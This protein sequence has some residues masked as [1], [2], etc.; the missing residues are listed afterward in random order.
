MKKSLK[1]YYGFTLVE[2]IIVITILAI[3][4]TIA[5][6]S[7]QNYTK[8]SR[9]T[10]R[11]SSLKNIE[12]GLE[13]FSVT[14]GN[15]PMPDKKVDILSSWSVIWYQ[16]YAWDSVLNIIKSSKAIDPLDWLYYNY[17]VDKDLKKYELLTFME[18]I[19]Y[20]NIDTTYA[21]INRIWK[22]YWDNIWII[23][24]ANNVP[25]QELFSTGIDL[26]FVTNNFVLHL[27]N[28]VKITWTWNI[29]K[30]FQWNNLF[31]SLIWYW[32]FDDNSWTNYSSTYLK[33]ITTSS[34][35]W[36]NTIS[37]SAWKIGNWVLFNWSSSWLTF[38]IWSNYTDYN[39]WTTI[40]FFVKTT[41]SYNWMWNASVQFWN[42]WTHIY[43]D[44][45]NPL[46]IRF[47]PN[48]LNLL[49]Q[50]NIKLANPF[51]SFINKDWIWKW[52]SN[53][54]NLVTDN[55]F[56]HHI[57]TFTNDLLKYYIDWNIIF[58]WNISKDMFGQFFLFWNSIDE[59]K[60]SDY[61]LVNWY[62]N[63][64]VSPERVEKYK[65]WSYYNPS[66]LYLW[67]S[68]YWYFDEIRVFNKYF[69]DKDVQNLYNLTK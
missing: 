14:T 27:L 13:I 51:Y 36:D 65:N 53:I 57:I 8:S 24:D 30:T 28:D 48:K 54:T 47:I 67:Q 38:P 25:I 41:W 23:T 39:S 45:D 15:L 42:F 59:Q 44:V 20:F 2:L 12:N 40:S 7:F 68:F 66:T 34:I 10:N 61:K 33:K 35:T 29:L 55:K 9:D 31:D 52:D 3:L 32:S 46:A 19:S 26:N 37:Y 17:S 43:W 5:F 62:I 18:N 60:I 4:S 16:W 21:S 63:K 6:V 22:T 64:N 56:H 49:N 69:E 11:I 50:E 58:S 1:K